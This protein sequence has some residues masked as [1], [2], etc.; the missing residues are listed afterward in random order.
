MKKVYMVEVGVEINNDGNYNVRING[1]DRQLYDENVVAFLDGE[2]AR[3]FLK[4]YVE[5]G[6][7]KTYGAL[8]ET[9]IDDDDPRLEEVVSIGF[10]E[11][12][13]MGREMNNIY[14]YQK[15]E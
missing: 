10:L 11:D 13:Y 15:G 7:S 3:S 12:E 4:N 8:W 1:K 14:F 2:K 5:K 9:T 6:V